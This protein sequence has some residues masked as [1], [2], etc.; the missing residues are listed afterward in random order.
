[1]W[2]AWGFEFVLVFGGLFFNLAALTGLL[3]LFTTIVRA[4]RGA[5]AGN[6]EV[7]LISVGSLL[8][9]GAVFVFVEPVLSAESACHW[10]RQVF[11]AGN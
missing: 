8:L 11:R 1:M 9:L 10:M 3:A 7:A 4:L 5:K 6:V 2:C